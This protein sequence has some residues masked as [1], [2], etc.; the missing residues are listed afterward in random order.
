MKTDQ[1]IFTVAATLLSVQSFQTH[2]D[3][4][5]IAVTQLMLPPCPK[6]SRRWLEQPCYRVLMS[7]TRRLNRLSAHRPSH[8]FRG[9]GS[10]LKMD[11]KHF[12]RDPNAIQEVGSLTFEL[13][14]ILCTA[15]EVVPVR[16]PSSGGA[17][18]TRLLPTSLRCPNKGFCCPYTER[19]HGTLHKTLC[20]VPGACRAP[21]SNVGVCLAL[22]SKKATRE[23]A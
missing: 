1:T 4:R 7:G 2:A 9:T 8:V 15:F 12:P 18:S 16:G 14:P 22:R 13:L 17:I 21:K 11:L 20:R 6:Q 3:N 23:K 10:S 19:R 5:D